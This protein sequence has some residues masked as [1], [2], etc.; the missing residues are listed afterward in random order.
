LAVAARPV[1]W[2]RNLVA[3]WITNFTG[4]LGVT[5][6]IPFVA[7]FLARD[8]GVHR[9]S[10]LAL[11]TG[12][13]A[14]SSGLGQA[15]AGPVWGALGDRFGRKPLLLRAVLMGGVVMALT[16]L[17]R[18]PQ[19]LL[20][21]RF[22][23]GLLAGPIPI[24]MAIVATETPRIH[25]ARSLGLLN[26]AVALAAGLGPALGAVVV[27][28]VDV[29]YVFAVAGVGL[30]IS[31]IFVIVMVTESPRRA[32]S[33]DPQPHSERL[34]G[35]LLGTVAFI[36]VALAVASTVTTM[37]LP[38]VS[39]RFLELVPER[40]AA[41]TGVAFAI[42]GVMTAIAG[43]AFGSILGRLR[44]R[45]TA[46]GSALILGVAVAVIAYFTALPPIFA[47]FAVYGFMNGLLLPVVSSV[48]AVEVPSRLHSTVFGMSASAAAI[49]Y[50][51]GPLLAGAVAAAT[52]VS[53][54]LAVAGGLSL[55]LSLLLGIRLR[56]PLASARS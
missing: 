39:L 51:A 46:I 25:V 5:A 16:S 41:V 55:V 19:E 28:I 17:S 40:A 53:V 52:S 38:L 29:R 12:S 22:A 54:S 30:L 15:I 11:W 14:A 8:L 23:F 35:T 26:S 4:I 1:N 34:A 48:M 36:L 33:H 32:R 21:Y 13:A 7:F 49:G 43:A 10:E 3:L 37:V 45:R 56:E 44:Y 31:S 2:R 18:S 20:M 47:G 24:A 9:P 27:G 50:T 6:M 42:S